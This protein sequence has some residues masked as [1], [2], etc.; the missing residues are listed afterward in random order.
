MAL[1]PPA[2]ADLSARVSE[3]SPSARGR[4][5]MP[6]RWRRGLGW[7]GFGLLCVFPLF[8]SLG[9]HPIHGDSEARYGV[10]ARG[11]AHGD[12][13]LL[14]PTLFGQPHLTKP[15]LTYWL[16]AGSIRLLG[17]GELA[18]RLPAAL[19]GVGTLMIVFG[20]TYRLHGARRAAMAA[21][22]LSITPM[23]LVIS[24]MGITDGPLGLFSTAALAA[25]LLAV[26][27]GKM[28]WVM[29]LWG[30]VALAL[31]TKGPPGLLAPASLV[32]W[33]L[34][35]R[36]HDPLRRIRPALGFA[37]A[38]LPLVGWGLLTAWRH[39][40]AWAIWKFQT[41]DRATGAGD[42]PEP[43]WFFAPVFVLGLLPATALLWANKPRFTDIRSHFANTVQDRAEWLLWA[44]M[45][46]LT[47]GVFSLIAGKL[48][49]Y[50][51][52][53]AAPMAWCGATVL[54]NIN[55]NKKST[56]KKNIFRILSALYF[57]GCG[58]T[59]WAI[60]KQLDLALTPI[61]WPTALAIGAIFFLVTRNQPELQS[62]ARS[63]LIVLWISL[64]QIGAWATAAEDYAYNTHSVPTLVS[65]V[66][67]ATGLSQ[68]Q[69]LTVGF[70]ERSLPYYTHQPTRRIDP[71][72]LPKAWAL[73][74]KDNLILIAEPSEW[75]IFDADPHWDLSQ[76]FEP[77]QIEGLRLGHDGQPLKAYRTTPA[78]RSP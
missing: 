69:I 77:I 36:Q 17:D 28:I 58:A 48:M 15:P 32:L 29:G 23:F 20:L 60:A 4:Q 35:T 74:R 26:R 42:H 64:A 44:I 12:A 21:A 10:V 34:M 6:A 22:I 38:L 45:I 14:V 72:V 71:R 46:I 65:A 66:E 16:M 43:W 1:M 19:S 2:A 68:P 5:P 59:G 55:Y 51:M 52:P 24:R 30:S 50:L 70:V 13:S 3:T 40:E 75:D 78:Y 25:G 67:E 39:P 62:G 73:M 57:L 63:R 54:E 41:L 56:Y 9:N 11:M 37:V 18:L 61:I 7:L 49:S 47:L 8:F 76:R 53:L 27:E 31:L 33:L